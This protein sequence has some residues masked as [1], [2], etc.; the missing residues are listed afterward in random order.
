VIH[1]EG[2]MVAGRFGNRAH[3]LTSVEK[4]NKT[5]FARLLRE[6]GLDALADEAVRPKPLY[7]G[8]RR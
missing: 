1:R 3:P 5:I 7:G 2:L 8:R 6:I 4:D